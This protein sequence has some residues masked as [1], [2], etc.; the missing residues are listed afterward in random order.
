MGT[1][2]VI[3]EVKNYTIYYKPILTFFVD[4]LINIFEKLKYLLSQAK[5]TSEEFD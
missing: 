2:V 4:K 1:A 5:L 3:V